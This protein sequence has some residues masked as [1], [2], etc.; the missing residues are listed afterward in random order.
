MEEEYYAVPDNPVYSAQIRKLKNED[1]ASADDTFNPLFGKIIENIAAV[2]EQTE[3]GG[4]YYAVC[5]TAGS[6]TAKVAACEGFTLKTGAAALVKFTNA[7]TAASPTL[8]IN[9]TGAKLIKRYGDTAYRNFWPAGAVVLFVYDGEN[10]MMITAQTG[11][12]YANVDMHNNVIT[13]LRTSYSPSDAV[14]LQTL[15]SMMANCVDTLT[16]SLTGPSGN[17]TKTFSVP[18]LNR[19]VAG[20]EVAFYLDA[21][22]S[23][24][25]PTGFNQI[26]VLYPVGVA[27]PMG[28]WSEADWLVFTLNNVNYALYPLSGVNGW[29][30]SFPLTPS[31]DAGSLAGYFRCRYNV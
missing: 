12:F 26:T 30:A 1:P 25:A 28:D 19:T 13:G 17:A 31:V 22:I 16:V 3:G 8:N 27:G 20:L 6:T 7:N 5:G 15:M 11:D 18:V 4:P 14:N 21:T 24:A 9:G 10:Y 2:K 23:G 29:T